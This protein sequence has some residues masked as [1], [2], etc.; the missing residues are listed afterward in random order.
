MM[1]AMIV[2]A[3]IILPYAL[4]YKVIEGQLSPKPL[5]ENIRI[6][7]HASELIKA[8][9]TVVRK[10]SPDMPVKSEMTPRVP[11]RNLFRMTTKYP[12]LTNHASTIWILSRLRKRILFFSRILLPI[13]TPILYIVTKPMV[14]PMVETTNRIQTL[15]LPVA[16]KYPAATS[17]TSLGNGGKM[18]SKKAMNP[19]KA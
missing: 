18:F 4:R 8:K 1:I 13:Q 10:G 2:I 19:E 16:V 5:P 17:T 6:I 3:K 12:Y 7:F 11:A 14:L 15:T 9:M